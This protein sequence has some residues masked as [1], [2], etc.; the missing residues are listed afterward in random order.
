MV[1]SG[2]MGNLKN[3]NELEIL[4]DICLPAQAG[5]LTLGFEQVMW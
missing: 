1:K 5:I 2:S 4:F 3:S